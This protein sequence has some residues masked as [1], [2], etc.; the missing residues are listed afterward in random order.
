MEPPLGRMAAALSEPPVSAPA[1]EGR[2]AAARR[3]FLR[4]AGEWAGR[5]GLEPPPTEAQGLVVTGHQVEFY[6]AG[7]WAKVIAA[8][9]IC[10]RAGASGQVAFDLLVDHDVV[11]HLGFDVPAEAEGGGWERKAVA[12]APPR[13]LAAEHLEAPTREAF[14]RWDA[15]V[16][17]HRGSDALAHWMSLLRPAGDAPRSYTQWMSR[18]RSR[19]ERAMDLRVHHVPTS[20]L[21]G[22]ASWLQFVHE[23]ITKADD[24]REAYNRHLA[25]YRQRQGI[26]NAQHPMP[27]LVRSDDPRGGTLVELPF[28]IYRPGEARERLFIRRCGEVLFLQTATAEH[29]VTRSLAPALAQG[30]MLRPRAL[31]LTMFVRLYIADVFIHGIG[32]ALYDQITDGLLRELYG[33][34]PPYGCVSAAWLLPLG[35]EYP[36]ENLSALTWRRHHALHNPQLSMDPFT[37]VRTDVAELVHDRRET[38]EQLGASLE[39]A[40]RDR[41]ARLHRRAL[42]ERLHRLNGHLHAKAPRI[43]A[44]LDRQL[45]DARRALEQNRVLLWREW[46]VAL[47]DSGSL[48]QLIARVRESP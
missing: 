36:L 40:R 35:K 46:F 1:V 43:L 32:G 8:D 34:A 41:D 6:H 11:D 20:L 12:F 27:D 25:A 3:D 21:C 37:A 39:A 2:R 28:W 48:R 5:L 18:A 19:F 44:N 30:F 22:T 15:A 45:A 4:I 16:A 29:D 42:F 31:A 24:R 13:A 9:A 26:N 17:R 14:E 47:H 7:V 10:R 38:I 33:V 23:W